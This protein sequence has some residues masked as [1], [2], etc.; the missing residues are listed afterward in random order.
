MIYNE[1]NMI[2]VNYILPY[3][4]IVNNITLLMVIQNKVLKITILYLIII[5]ININGI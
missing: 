2:N 5:I 3:A 1:A 4:P